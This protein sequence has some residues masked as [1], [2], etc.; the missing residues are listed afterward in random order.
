MHCSVRDNQHRRP[1]S[2]PAMAA[3]LI[4]A[5]LFSAG[6]PALAQG[7]QPY[8]AK[9]IEVY[10]APA[11][12]Q[13]KTKEVLP[14]Q[15]PQVRTNQG[16]PVHPVLVKPIEP[17]KPSSPLNRAVT[18]APVQSPAANPSTNRVIAG[19]SLVEPLSNGLKLSMTK[20]EILKQFGEPKP[21]WDSRTMDY[22][23]FAVTVG[24][25]DKEIW[26]FTI[27]APGLK[28]NSG[29]QVGSTK[30][31]VES[32]CGNAQGGQVGQYKLTFAYD[33]AG[34]VHSIRI[35]PAEN[36]FQAYD[37]GAL[38]QRKKVV[39]A[40]AFVGTWHGHTSASGSFYSVGTLEIRADHTYTYNRSG[41]GQYA[42][43]G[44]QITF[45][46]GPLTAWNRGRANY[47]KDKAIEFYWKNEQGATQW[48]VFTK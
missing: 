1:I 46:S 7:I 39:D 25:R 22:G 4:T 44:A 41:H 11:I 36:R 24:G 29:L 9:E 48:F 45:T 31:Q 32:V 26:H 34:V 6:I 17:L 21:G 19:G 13:Q 3:W 33:N 16:Q 37:S 18:N 40:A 8:K 30:G 12:Q 10:K 2:F 42:T 43:Q 27:K 38:D 47:T 14:Y 5:D 28:L 35:D 20:E 15:A 23:Q